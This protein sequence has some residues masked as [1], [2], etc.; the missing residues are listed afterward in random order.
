MK[1]VIISGSVK[2]PK[3]SDTKA[4]SDIMAR[5]LEANDIT[6]EVINLKDFDYEAT[7][8]GDILLEQMSKL[9]DANIILFAG[10]SFHC[11]LPFTM[12]NIFNRFKNA[13][14]KGM[15]NGIDIFEGKYFD[16]CFLFSSDWDYVGRKE[17]ININDFDKKHGITYHR[18][19]EKIHDPYTGRQHNLVYDILEFMKP[20]GGNMLTVC[21]EAPLNEQGPTRD[22]MSTDK[23]INKDIERFIEIAKQ[24]Y[25]E[26]PTPKCSIEE[27]TSFF[28]DTNAEFGR[29]M[30]LK[31]ENI[32][33][34]NVIKNIDH[35]MMNKNL[36]VINHAQIM[37]CMKER[38]EK[39]G[40]YDLSNYYFRALY[41]LIEKKGFRAQDAGTHRSN[42]Y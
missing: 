31:P 20:L 23:K 12:Y 11:L 5:K 35:V 27:F 8:E 30:T 21:L 25:V 38:A 10:P 41:N 14:K 17:K 34:D 6:A 4:W 29:G 40:K 2:D 9:Y 33:R 15:A 3:N 22:Q 13:Y 28:E 16:L 26:D 42:N 1:V 37:L 39:A 36:E 18:P 19:R 7:T 24:N 32:N